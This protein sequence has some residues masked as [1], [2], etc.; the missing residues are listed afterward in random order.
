MFAGVY[1]HVFSPACCCLDIPPAALAAAAHH[2]HASQ[3]E[4][5]PIATYKHP[6]KPAFC[7]V[8]SVA[9]LVLLL[10]VINVDH[11]VTE[12]HLG[13]IDMQLCDVT[14]KP[15]DNKCITLNRSAAASCSYS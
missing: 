2:V 10:Q 11:L 9:V 14:A 6:H 15:G 7:N 5:T 13:R 4:C 1:I 12:N 8:H 3:L